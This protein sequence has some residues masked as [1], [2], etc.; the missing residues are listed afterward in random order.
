MKMID[1]TLALKAT[2]GDIELLGEVIHAFLEE[3]P[4]LL[5]EIARGVDTRDHRAVQLA[6]HTIKGT[7]R[8]FGDIPARQT[9]GELEEMGRSGDLARAEKTFS[10]LRSELQTFHEQ[11]LE[12]LKA[13]SSQ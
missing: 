4:G 2:E 11:V 8:I 5:K 10:A 13:R 6:S 7:L 3:Y 9:A 12:S 1:L